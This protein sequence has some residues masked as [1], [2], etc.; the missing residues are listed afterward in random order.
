MTLFIIYITLT[1]GLLYLAHRRERAL[2]LAI[3]QQHAM[4]EGAINRDPS[5]KVYVGACATPGLIVSAFDK[6]S[7]QFIKKRFS[8]GEWEQYG[9]GNTVLL[10]ARL[11]LHS[12]DRLTIVIKPLSEQEEGEKE[13]R[14]LIVERKHP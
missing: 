2:R 3:T 10:H 11:Y 14:R 6:K 9:M 1:G 13:I 4:G 5:L 12:D 8:K 7:A